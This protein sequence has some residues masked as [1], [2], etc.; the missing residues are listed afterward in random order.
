MATRKQPTQKG[1]FKSAPVRVRV[2]ASSANLGSGFDCAGLSLGLYDDVVAQVVDEPG[3]AVDIHGEGQEGVPRD[4]RNL[5]AQAMARTFDVLGV[6]PTGVALVCANRI[7]HGKGLGSSAAATCAG[8][9]L[10]CELVPGADSKLS[11]SDLI[12]LGSEIEGHP[13]NVAACLGGGLT[14][15]WQNRNGDDQ[16]TTIASK[17]WPVLT[18]ITPVICL[19]ASA[20]STK[21]ARSVLPESVPLKDAASQA[22][23]SAL[24]LA[25]FTQDS[26]LLFAATQ[27]FLHQ[28]YR[29]ELMPA[30]F[31][32]LTRLR[33]AGVAAAFSGAGPSLI[34]LVGANEAQKVGD[35]AGP[36][37]QTMALGVDLSGSR[38]EP[39]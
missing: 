9:V 21:K 4:H 16:A 12:S 3:F 30:S 35:L 33:A 14:L 28:R 23:R 6:S 19:P 5:V 34:C 31:Q 38:V 15:S 22:A 36:D 26:S 37:F 27:D 20:N 2:P 32:A 29:R 10:A 39:L 18:E 7:P 25:A 1:A 13:D 24:L 8:M 17:S 11:T